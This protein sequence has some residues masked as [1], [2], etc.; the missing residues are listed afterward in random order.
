MIT[1]MLLAATVGQWGGGFEGGR[2]DSW[3]GTRAQYSRINISYDGYN[4][5]LAHEEAVAQRI[6]NWEDYVRTRWSLQD[7]WLERERRR[8]SY[9]DSLERR[10]K[11]IARVKM[12]TAEYEALTGRK[13]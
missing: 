12:L 13:P 11:A 8:L 6:R 5:E 2:I 4:P 10:I 7:S 3:G 1:T 9:A